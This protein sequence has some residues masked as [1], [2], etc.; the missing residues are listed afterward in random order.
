MLCS[1]ICRHA[2]NINRC[3]T[4]GRLRVRRCHVSKLNLQ[5]LRADVSCLRALLQPCIK[6]DDVDVLEATIMEID[7]TISEPERGIP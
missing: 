7:Q 1:M 3:E 2:G 6:S 5:F 4:Y